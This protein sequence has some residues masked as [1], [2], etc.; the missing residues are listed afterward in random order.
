MKTLLPNNVFCSTFGH[1]YFKVKNVNSET[2]EIVCKCCGNKFLS[3]SQGD[4]LQISFGNN[5][6]E[7]LIDYLDFQEHRFRKKTA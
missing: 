5:D 4:V 3:T 7:T 1:N 6:I 2:S